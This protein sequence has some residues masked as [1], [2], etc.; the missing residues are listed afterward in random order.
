MRWSYI[1]SRVA[2]SL[3]IAAAFFVVHLVAGDGG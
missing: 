1:L 3:L 2:A